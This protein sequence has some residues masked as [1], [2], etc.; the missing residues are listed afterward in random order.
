MDRKKRPRKRSSHVSQKSEK[1]IDFVSFLF[2]KE[3]VLRVF[4]FLSSQ[5]LITCTVVSHNWSRIANDE[6]LWK[7]LFYRKFQNLFLLK[8][9]RKYYYDP[10]IR[11]RG[12]WKTKYR[13]HHNWLYGNCQIRD[14]TNVFHTSPNVHQYFQFTHDIIFTAQ[15]DSSIIKVWRYNN[16]EKDNFFKLLGQIQSLEVQQEDIFITYLKLTTTEKQYLIAGYSNGGFTIWEFSTNDVMAII[17]NTLVD[18]IHELITYF[19]TSNQ[20]K[21]KS[22]GMVYPMIV[23]YT[24]NKKLSIF[25]FNNDTL[26]LIDQLQSAVDWQPVII[27]IYPISN[28]DYKKLWKVVLCFGL[29][30]G[31]GNYTSTAVG[32][33]EIILST[34]S[35]LFSRQGFSIHSEPNVSS[36]SSN[37]NHNT[38]SKQLI[39]SMAYTPPYIIT[40]HP[41]NT[42]KQY[43]VTS[44]NNNQFSVTFQQIL[45]GHAFRVDALAISDQKL[46]SGDRSGL[47][48]WD[49]FL[50]KQ[51][52]FVTVNHYKEQSNM[53]ELPECQI[54]SLNFDEDKIMAIIN[55]PNHESS[56]IRLWSFK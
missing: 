5:D 17:N 46:I 34:H 11:Y 7:P 50:L 56:F 54:E 18:E 10:V 1:R 14:V 49:L 53:N 8:E 31:E 41:N 30:S 12:S 20:N 19:P 35:I 4:S 23:V 45:Y 48:I 42:M 16:N 15:S 3:L 47:K 29:L 9:T 6:M 39:T 21:V 28:H 13:I 25:H 52:D 51:E 22:I 32:I 27:N 24:E 43:L 37:Y 38:A 40:A 2:S 26:K 36:Y 55:L 44:D 33:Q